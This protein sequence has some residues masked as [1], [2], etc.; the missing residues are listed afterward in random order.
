MGTM[1]QS[2]SERAAQPGDTWSTWALTMTNGPKRAAVTSD[3]THN[4]IVGGNW[5]AG[6][7]RYVEP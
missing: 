4:I 7:W 2:Q 3:G 1:D 5:N 6:L